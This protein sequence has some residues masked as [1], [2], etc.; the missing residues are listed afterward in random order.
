MTTLQILREL[1][2]ELPAE[3]VICDPD[4]MA[5]YRDD[6]SGEPGGM[7]LA[8]LRPA[9]V[10]ELAAA[11]RLCNRH[12]VGI[13]PQGGRTGLSGGACAHAGGVVVSTERMNGII[14]LDRRAMTLTAWAGTPLQVIQEAALAAGLEYPVDIGARGTA[15][16]G[17]TVATNAGGIRVI[18]HGMTRSHVAGLEV[19]L[20]DSTVI[21]DLQRLEKDNAGYDLKHLFTGSEGTLGIVTRVCLR[22]K[23]AMPYTETALLGLRD[24]EAAF[25]LLEAARAQLGESL[26][27]F[28]GMWPDFFAHV[29]DEAALCRAPLAGRQGFYVLVEAAHRSGAGAEGF[30]AWLSEMLES[31]RVED[32][33]VA[34]S[35]ADAAALWKI[36]ESVTELHRSFGPHL[37]FDIG[38]P[39]PVVGHFAEA[40]A[41]V[42]RDRR[43]LQ[44]G[45][46][47][48]GNLHLLVAR[49]AG[50]TDHDIEQPVFELVRQWH[51]TVSAEHGI[52]L[53]K[54]DWLGHSR[55][56]QQRD[57]MRRIKHGLDPAGI[58]NRGKLLTSPSCPE[59]VLEDPTA[60]SM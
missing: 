14:H 47:G 45:H 29:C 56:P 26:V 18:R 24:H 13:V 48:D 33:A 8:V 23:H 50:D 16:I 2:R 32:G 58:M 52:G 41:G 11:V 17:G 39:P 46:V 4:A 51:G 7:P 53:L 34:R 25:A 59:S 28:E 38:L 35:G 40:V 9:S 27:A 44:F 5:R 54:R 42:L 22:L 30:H 21:D 3:V 12:A 20:A 60:M 19:V 1:R 36:R 43:T 57:V 10:D 15:T 49:E 31:G 55:S 6:A 37:S